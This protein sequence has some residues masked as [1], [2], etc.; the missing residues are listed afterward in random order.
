MK[1]NECIHHRQI[2][3][4]KKFFRNAN[5]QK[6]IGEKAKEATGKMAKTHF[7]ERIHS[8]KLKW[9]K[10]VDVECIFWIW[11]NFRFYC[12]TYDFEYNVCVVFCSFYSLYSTFFSVRFLHLIQHAKYLTITNV[13]YCAL[14]NVQWVN[15]NEKP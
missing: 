11:P 7:I 2:F 15:E 6:K 4:W 3:C 1:T 13:F 14:V 9:S 10:Y 8:G 12:N 5:E